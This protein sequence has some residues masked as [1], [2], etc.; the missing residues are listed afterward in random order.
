M[1]T[2]LHD[3]KDVVVN[4]TTGRAQYTGRPLITAKAVSDC[5]HGGMVLISGATF[6]ALPVSELKGLGA[7]LNMGEHRCAPRALPPPS[8]G[9]HACGE[10]ERPRPRSSMCVAFSCLGGARAKAEKR[11]RRTSHMGTVGGPPRL[12]RRFSNALAHH[13]AL[14][15]VVAPGMHARLSQFE[16]ALRRS[17][18]VPLQLGVLQAPVE[19]ASIAFVTLV[20]AS[21]LLAWDAEATGRAL[22]LF[23]RHANDVLMNPSAPLGSGYVVELAAG[24]LLASFPDP[25]AA[26]MASL[27]LVEELLHA[28]WEPD[29]LAHV[30]CEEVCVHNTSVSVTGLLART[31]RSSARTT[32][33]NNNASTVASSATD[34]HPEQMRTA[35]LMLGSLNGL[36]RATL[37]ADRASVILSQPLSVVG[38]RERS[39]Q[40]VTSERAFEQPARTV[41]VCSCVRPRRSADCTEW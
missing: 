16:P 4:A 3:A 11:V 7:M 5:A 36:D 25:A 23:Q 33:G 2:G 10:R 41:R 15:Q 6:S 13:G 37:T 40:I 29:L 30:L 22:Q 20:G 18:T 39:S 35:L 17:G 19:H 31:S 14:Y 38:H 34:G 8:R 12:P 9:V 28:A 32:T 26:V 21:T 1:H 27:H 24:L